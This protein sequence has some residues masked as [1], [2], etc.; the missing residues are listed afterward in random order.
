MGDTK[1][2]AA[3]IAARLFLDEMLEHGEEHLLHDFLA[4][5]DA[6]SGRK[7]ITKESVPPSLEQKRNFLFE[8]LAPRRV[9]AS[10][11]REGDCQYRQLLRSAPGGAVFSILS[12][13]FGRYIVL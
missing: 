11:S 5:L 4:I 7:H 3:Q 8:A 12:S 6:Q 1:S 9:N 10:L 2:P 13:I